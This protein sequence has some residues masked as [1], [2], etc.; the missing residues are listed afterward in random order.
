MLKKYF[1]RS[2][3]CFPLKIKTLWTQRRALTA[4]TATIVISVAH[5]AGEYINSMLRADKS[6]GLVFV[7]YENHR[8]SGVTRFFGFFMMYFNIIVVLLIPFFLLCVLNFK[9]CTGLQKMNNSRSQ[10]TS[11]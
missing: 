9:I 3:A 4:T 6:I 5:G 2:L 10:L 11:V 1:L 7:V 8:P